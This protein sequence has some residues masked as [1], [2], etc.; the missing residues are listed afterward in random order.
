MA[1]ANAE[2]REQSIAQLFRELSQESAALV[3]DE[4]QRMRDEL[5]DQDRKSVV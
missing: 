1:G 4:L 2:D 3:R 5:A